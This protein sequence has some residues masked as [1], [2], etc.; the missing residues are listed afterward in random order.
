[1]TM[2][3]PPC[4]LAARHIMLSVTAGL[5]QYRLFVSV[6]GLFPSSLSG[7]EAYHSTQTGMR[8]DLVDGN[9]VPGE[10]VHSLL[11]ATPREHTHLIWWSRSLRDVLQVQ[12][13]E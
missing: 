7:P 1:M 11:G 13:S 5:C 6:S 2:L 8:V 10:C 4:S 3:L 9:I 12:K